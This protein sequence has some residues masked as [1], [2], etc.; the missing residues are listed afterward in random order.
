MYDIES[1]NSTI[2]V[3]LD[4]IGSISWP[5]I[6]LIIF[7]VFRSPISKLIATLKTLK[8]KDWTLEFGDK[9]PVY[10]P[11]DKAFQEVVLQPP[12]PAVKAQVA[13]ISKLSDEE[14]EQSRQRAQKRLDEDTKRVGYQRGKLFQVPDSGKWAI[15]WDL[16]V[17]DR[18]I[19][20]ES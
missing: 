18:V 7:W 6:V 9:I 20:G 1:W 5:I 14:I 12:V 8:W 3:F 11:T 10:S 2:K 17:S 4:F 16:E 19:I 15:A 13:E